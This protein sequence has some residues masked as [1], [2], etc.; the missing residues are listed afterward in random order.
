[1][2]TEVVRFEYDKEANA[3]YIYL[4]GKI[5][6]GGAAGTLELA[7]GVYLDA[8]RAGRILGVEFLDFADFRGFLERNGGRVDIPAHLSDLEASK[9]VPF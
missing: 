1:V 5:P 4:L 6:E 9:A 7:S 8:D 2:H 3:L